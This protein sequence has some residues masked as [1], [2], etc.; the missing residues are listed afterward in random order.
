MV[1]NC[2]L[3]II[4]DNMISH[5]HSKKKNVYNRTI[6]NNVKCVFCLNWSRLKSA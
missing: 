1:Y 5:K 3:Y 6:G 4:Y 2:I